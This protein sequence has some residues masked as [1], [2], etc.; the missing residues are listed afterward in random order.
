MR[1]LLVLPCW[2]VCLWGGLSYADEPSGILPSAVSPRTLPVK[3]SA[4][5][6][7]KRG[8]VDRREAEPVDVSRSS[9]AGV[10][11]GRYGSL[12]VMHDLLRTRQ[13]SHD[14]LLELQYPAYLTHALLMSST[15]AAAHDLKRMPLHRFAAP[16]RPDQ[17][18]EIPLMGVGGPRAFHMF[19]LFTFV[20]GRTDSA[21]KLLSSQ[22]KDC[23]GALEAFRKASYAYKLSGVLLTC[24]GL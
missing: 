9:A 3:E 1:Q 4:N 17:T 21:A 20:E 15:E 10:I 12:L 19:V 13:S 8:E 7:H 22:C 24:A 11:G 5:V 14:G 18:S 23:A 2:A 16:L 6:L